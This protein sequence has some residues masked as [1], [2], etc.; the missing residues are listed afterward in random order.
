MNQLIYFLVSK[1]LLKV[2]PLVQQAKYSKD[3]LLQPV[4]MVR[5]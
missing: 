5:Q 3:N 4:H 1:M 2:L